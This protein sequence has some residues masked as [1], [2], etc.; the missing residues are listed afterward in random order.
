MVF[1]IAQ[2]N[3]INSIALASLFPHINRTPYI[4]WLWF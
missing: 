2:G 1:L 3:E 4:A